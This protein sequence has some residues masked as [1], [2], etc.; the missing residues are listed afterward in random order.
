MT[1]YDNG[2][3]NAMTPYGAAAINSLVMP[4]PDGV[5]SRCFL[6]VPTLGYTSIPMPQ[7]RN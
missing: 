3:A 7:R 2:L 4:L 6:P 1:K 5:R